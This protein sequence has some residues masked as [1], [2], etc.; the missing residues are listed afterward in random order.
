MGQEAGEGGDLV[1]ANVFYITFP[2]FRRRVTFILGYGL[3]DAP[4]SNWGS[5]I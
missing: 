5:Q 3:F 1:G 2:N 4:A